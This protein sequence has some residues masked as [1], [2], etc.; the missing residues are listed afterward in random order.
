MSGA[1]S[2]NLYRIKGGTV[3]TGT[4]TKVTNLSSSVVIPNLTN[5]R[6]YSFIVTAVNAYGEGGPSAVAGG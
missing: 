2:Y 6:L 4:G 1:V 3:S 5:G